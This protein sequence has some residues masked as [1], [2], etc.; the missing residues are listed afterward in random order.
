MGRKLRKR[1]R[2]DPEAC[3]RRAHSGQGPSRRL[4]SGRLDPAGRAGPEPQNL[5][6]P[7]K[8]PA[9]SAPG[10]GPAIPDAP[11]PS[12]PTPAAGE[13]WEEPATPAAAS[14]DP[15]SR[16][17][18]N[19]PRH[20]NSRGA[21]S[22]CAHSNPKPAPPTSPHRPEATGLHPLPLPVRTRSTTAPA[23]LR[24]SVRMSWK[25]S[26]SR[27]KRGQPPDVVS[28][29][30]SRRGHEAGEAGLPPDVVNYVADEVTRRAGR[31]SQ[32]PVPRLQ[33]D[34]QL[35]L[36]PYFAA[37]FAMNLA[38]SFSKSGLQLLQH[39]FTSWP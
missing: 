25:F 23:G 16:R 13:P 22:P 18:S 32:S 27:F 9:P 5:H 21:L 31:S 34:W 14:N 6:P 7:T 35:R 8:P 3:R 29:T 33:S 11:P 38:G 4:R 37:S 2:T 30:C 24:S 17:R 20:P 10:R 15:T 36:L 1:P 39:S 19:P 26:V 12:A 28:Y